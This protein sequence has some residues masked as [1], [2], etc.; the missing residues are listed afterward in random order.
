MREPQVVKTQS[1]RKRAGRT[2]AERA[3]TQ[4]IQRADMVT[5]YEISRGKRAESQLSLEN[6]ISPLGLLG[7]IKKAEGGPIHGKYGQT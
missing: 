1:H 6:E 3:K 5:A 2:R 4:N 7:Y